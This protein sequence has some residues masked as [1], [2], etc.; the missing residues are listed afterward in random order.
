MIEK[1][2]N[3]KLRFKL[4]HIFICAIIILILI[5]GL[6]FN[7]SFNFRSKT[8]KFALE[9]VGELVT[10][11]AH[12]TIVQD[13]KVHREFFKLFELPFTESRQIFSYDVEVDASVDFTKIT[14]SINVDEKNIIIKLPHAKIYKTT[15]DTESMVIYLDEE[16]IFSRI[17][18]KKQNDAL[19]AMKMQGELDAIENG[20]LDAADKNAKKLIEGFIKSYQEYNDYHI[21]YQYV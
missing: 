9:N 19:T 1:M 7:P 11:T 6:V 5:I 14:Y 12:L 13:N 2:K 4:S 18:L 17:D 10:Q 21:S 20:I 8:T 3:K 16:S 15:I